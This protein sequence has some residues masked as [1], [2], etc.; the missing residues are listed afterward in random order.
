MQE[1][2]MGEVLEGKNDLQEG[3][4]PVLESATL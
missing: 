1:N 3:F 4:L 2:W